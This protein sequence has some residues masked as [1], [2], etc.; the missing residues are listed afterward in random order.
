[1]PAP[2]LPAEFA[3]C[4][5]RG[6]AFKSRGPLQ[7]SALQTEAPEIRL[8]GPHHVETLLAEKPASRSRQEGP[9][10]IAQNAI[11]AAQDL[12]SH[13]EPSALSLYRSRSSRRFTWRRFIGVEASS[14]TK[15]QKSPL[16][17]SRCGARNDMV[18]CLV[19]ATS[20]LPFVRRSELSV[21]LPFAFAL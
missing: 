7:L 15:A 10:L 8:L 5:R 12:V 6:S 18:T 17:N 9:K 13:S 3:K 20:I 16:Q 14:I 21:L 11:W 1:M 4:P 2:P 19:T